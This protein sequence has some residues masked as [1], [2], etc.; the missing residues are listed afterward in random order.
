MQRWTNISQIPAGFGPSIVTIGNFDGVHRGHQ[1]VLARMVEDAQSA[2]QQAIA[3]TF[4]PHPSK[5]HRPEDNVRPLT[6]LEQRLDLLEASGIDAVLVINYTLEFAQQTPEA[7]VL[8]YLVHLLNPAKIVVGH[9]V[10]FGY[11]NTGNLETLRALG[12]EYGFDVEAIDD[13]GSEPEQ[14][15]SSTATRELLSVGDVAAAARV[16]GRE[17]ELRGVV[18]HGDK[19]GRDLGFPTANLG[20]NIAGFI[21]ADGVYAGRLTVIA[22]ADHAA[23]EALPAAISVGTNPTFDGTERRVEA[24]VLGRDDLEIYDAQIRIEFVDRVRGQVK[25]DG[26]DALIEQMHKDCARAAEILAR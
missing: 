16:L 13:A 23:T 11:G 22:C 17:H 1:M 6:S 2:G 4:D 10:R 7:F 14:R 24:Y 19:R 18:V 12:L 26:I 21:P 3:I 15:W 25:F 20:G 9:D 8:T 5:V